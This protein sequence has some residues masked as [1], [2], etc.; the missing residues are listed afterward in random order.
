[1]YTP[2]LH[3]NAPISEKLAA[4]EKIKDTIMKNL[5][6]PQIFQT[7]G[8]MIDAYLN[9]LYAQ[10]IKKSDQ[11]TIERFNKL[12]QI[13][14]YPIEQMFTVFFNIFG[15]FYSQLE[16]KYWNVL[17]Q[18]KYL[19][20]VKEE[21]EDSWIL[22]EDELKEFIME[23]KTEELT[24]Y[25]NIKL[26]NMSDY[27]P[28]VEYQNWNLDT[29]WEEEVEN[30]DLDI[31]HHV[32][33]YLEETELNPEAEYDDISSRLPAIPEEEEEIYILDD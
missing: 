22:L 1:M 32:S 4:L 10:F 11:A 25:H 21:I 6:S 17:E 26:F 5:T 28:Q 8:T 23:P 7:S 16:R 15:S 27:L 12:Q 19:A 31:S 18:K 20:D 24:I 33:E 29:S 2:L 13:I 14:E 3:S 30:Q 9:A